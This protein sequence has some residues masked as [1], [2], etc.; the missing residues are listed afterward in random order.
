MLLTRCLIPLLLLAPAFAQRRGAP[1]PK[2]PAAI[3]D[4]H[5]TVNGSESFTL[6]QVDGDWFAT[7]SDSHVSLRL[8]GATTRLD[9]QLDGRN[10]TQTITA[11]NN[12]DLGGAHVGFFWHSPGYDVHPRGSEAITVQVSRLDDHDFEARLSG[13]ADGVRLAGTIHVHRDAVPA[14]KLTGSFGECDNVIHDKL[15]MAQNRSPSD[16]EVKFDRMAREALLQ[17]LRPVAQFLQAHDWTVAKQSEIKTITGLARR[18]EQNPYQLNSAPE[19]IVAIEFQLTGAAMAQYQQRFQT[20]TQ[21]AAEDLKSAGRP[22][23]SYQQAI[24]FAHEMEGATKL[25]VSAAINVPSVGISSF[26]G[27]H[28][29][30]EI[31]GAAYALSISHVQASTGGGAENSHDESVILLG[32]WSAP[33]IQPHSDGGEHIGFKAVLNNAAPLTVQNIVIRIQANPANTRQAVAQID[34]AALQRLIQRH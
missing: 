17:A 30:L 10:P 20:L 31:P 3:S 34:F 23:P 1:P 18:T 24:D 5:I 14:A 26:G 25:R 12:S 9:L 29:P 21:R 11:E 32:N 19:G 27:G 16:C 28:T 22:G 7:P 8:M 6:P 13:T 33:A 15:A 2:V 4:T